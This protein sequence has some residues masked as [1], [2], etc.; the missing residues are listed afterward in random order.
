MDHQA[1]A[2]LLGNY[3]EFVGAIAVVATLAYLAVQ[4]RLSKEATNA[5]ALQLEQNTKALRIDAKARSDATTLTGEI[6]LMGDN[7]SIAYAKAQLNPKE[8]DDSEIQQVSGYLAVKASAIL[9]AYGSYKDGL[10]DEHQW[11]ELMRAYVVEFNYPFARAF[12]SSVA[13]LAPPEF[14][15]EME[16][17]YQANDTQD[18]VHLAALKKA[19]KA[20]LSKDL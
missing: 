5:V 20:E 16:K 8:L 19:L 6:A 15:I 11:E 12:F 17:A 18:F 2:Q 13:P 9:Q 10:L 14:T 7:L 4:I 3:G 1:F